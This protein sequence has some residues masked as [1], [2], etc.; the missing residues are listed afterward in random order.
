MGFCNVGCLGV[1]SE[2][3]DQPLQ[4]VK[5]LQVE[6]DGLTFDDGLD[7]VEQTVDAAS[8]KEYQM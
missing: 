7:P 2:I 5:V 4:L 8:E 3:V 6:V 1:V